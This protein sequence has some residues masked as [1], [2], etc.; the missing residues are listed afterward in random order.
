MPIRG[1]GGV[2][3]GG[4]SR[5]GGADEGEAACADRPMVGLVRAPVRSGHQHRPRASRRPAVPDQ[6]LGAAVSPARAPLRGPR[7]S[8]SLPVA[9]ISA[10]RSS[11][12]SNIEAAAGPSM[13]AALVCALR[14]AVLALVNAA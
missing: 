10:W 8:A 11:H 12:W 14:Q 3:A 5:F 7:V 9:G 2:G 1:Q 6:L 4:V 13:V